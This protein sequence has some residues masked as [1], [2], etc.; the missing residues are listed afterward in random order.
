[1]SYASIA[2]FC[3]LLYLVLD[4]FHLTKWL[5]PLMILC[6]TLAIVFGYLEDKFGFAR[7][8]YLITTNRMGL[9]K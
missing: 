3:M 9:D 7:E 5:I 8:E 1:M 4:K 6:I 2:N